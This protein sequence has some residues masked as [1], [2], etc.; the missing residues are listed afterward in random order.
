MNKEA[1][2]M[3]AVCENGI[4]L[5]SSLCITEEESNERR[6]YFVDGDCENDDPEAAYSCRKVRVTIEEITTL[7]FP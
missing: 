7:I 3:W 1:I 5:I 2:E 4:P 6:G